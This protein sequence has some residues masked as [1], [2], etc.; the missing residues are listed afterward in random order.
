M[1]RVSDIHIEYQDMVANGE[2]DE[3]PN[4]IILEEKQ[5]MNT[6]EYKNEHDAQA[7]KVTLNE[8]LDRGFTL[9]QISALEN[10][11]EQVFGKPTKLRS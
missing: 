1:G 6:N 3:M 5:Y 2:L 11:A 4:E 10:E 9:K 7:Y 8:L